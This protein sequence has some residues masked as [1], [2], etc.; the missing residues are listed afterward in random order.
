MRFR[1]LGKFAIVGVLLGVLLGAAG[2]SIVVQAH[3]NLVRSEPAADEILG[4]A[5]EE[6]RL[7]FSEAVDVQ[8]SQIQ[9]YDKLSQ[10]INGSPL[11][12]HGDP[13]DDTLLVAP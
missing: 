9:L 5:P 3:A 8:F 7:W 4:L 11:S 12:V 10:Q 6:L 2:A 13:G 1:S